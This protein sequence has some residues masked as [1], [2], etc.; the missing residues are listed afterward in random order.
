VPAGVSV[1][2]VSASLGLGLLVKVLRI[3]GQRRDLRVDPG[4]IGQL[5]EAAQA[6]SARLVEYADEDVVAFNQFMASR[7]LA[8]NTPEEQQERE[9]A[10]D[11]ALRAAIEVPLKTARAAVAGLDLCVEAAGSV[12]AFVAADLGAAAALLAGAVRATLLSVDFNVGQLPRD[13]NY[14]RDV[15]A[16]RYELQNRALRTADSL[17]G[18]FLEPLI[19]CK[20]D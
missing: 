4:R 17:I 16:E 2:A 7:R 12:H 19:Q 8:K 15:R 1:A 9:R 11:A 6:A 18:N 20:S 14:Y 3:V 13:S 10:M 5:R